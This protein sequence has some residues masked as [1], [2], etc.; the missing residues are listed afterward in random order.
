M[1]A[2]S[3]D[4]LVAKVEADLVSYQQDQYLGFVEDSLARLLV[5]VVVEEMVLHLASDLKAVAAPVFSAPVEPPS[6]DFFAL[7]YQQ[8]VCAGP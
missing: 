6:V 8:S 4:D 1:E 3:E 7:V 2:C 5:G